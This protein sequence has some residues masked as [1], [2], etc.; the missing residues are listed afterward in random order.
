MFSPIVGKRKSLSQGIKVLKN[1]LF[2]QQRW[3]FSDHDLA[4]LELL[5]SLLK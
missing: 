1:S 3:P 4:I 5:F 2:L